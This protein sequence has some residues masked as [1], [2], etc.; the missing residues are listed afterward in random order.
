MAGQF[1]LVL[2]AAAA[3]WLWEIPT[4]VTAQSEPAAELGESDEIEEQAASSPPR[5]P[6]EPTSINKI[7][8]ITFGPGDSVHQ[9]FGHNAFVVEGTA[10][11]QPTVFNYGMFTFGPDM[12]PQF[13]RGRLRFWL[14]LTQLERTVAQYAAAN[15]DV[16]LL[17]LNLTPSQRHIVF[18]RLSTDAR[19]ENRTYLYDHYQDNCSTRVRDVLDAA[20]RGQLRGAWSTSARLTLRQQTM[21][22]TQH[23]TLAQ[24]AMMFGLNGSVDRTQSAWSNAFLP[25][26][27]EALLEHTTY[28]N[29]N[30][31]RVPLVSKVTTLHRAQRP[32]LAVGPE[33]HARE[34]LA[35]G[36]LIALLWLLL[37]ERARSNRGAARGVLVGATAIYGVVGG[38]LGT[39]LCYLSLWSDHAVTHGNANLFLLSP[40][41]LVGGLLCLVE[42]AL[43]TTRRAAHWVQRAADAV[44]F[45]QCASS[46]ALL[47]IKLAPLGFEQDVS[48]PLSLLL[49]INV[50]IAL[51]RSRQP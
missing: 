2:L 33:D 47:A 34:L 48:Y 7:S 26:E 31:E 32:A 49:P 14:G 27:L 25:L 46:L 23:D 51:T 28:L 16:R 5:L 21:R 41:T 29:D 50:G 45:V 17:E 37:G 35:V 38:L 8:V 18:A 19:P 6:R 36:G 39:L 1:L 40:L 12:L 10:L 22:Y 3:G 9:Y 15:R 11:P 13:L 44:W 20:L 24:W 42:L 4:S 30:A 43:G